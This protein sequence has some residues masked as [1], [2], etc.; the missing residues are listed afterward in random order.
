MFHEDA[1]RTPYCNF[2]SGTPKY[3]SHRRLLSKTDTA[4]ECADLVLAR[5]SLTPIAVWDSYTKQ[6]WAI[7]LEDNIQIH[8]VSCRTCQYCL[9]QVK[10]RVINITK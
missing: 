7:Y 6:C 8:T 9:L 4:Q 10:G 3:Y 5:D 1:N 2:L